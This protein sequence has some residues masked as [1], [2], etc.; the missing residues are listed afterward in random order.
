MPRIRGNGRGRAPVEPAGC[1]D[2]AFRAHYFYRD[3][4]ASDEYVGGFREWNDSSA[5]GIELAGRRIFDDSDDRTLFVGDPPCLEAPPGTEWARVGEE[6]EHGW[7]Q[8]FRPDE[9]SLPDVLASREGRFFLRVYDPDVSLLDSEAF[10]YV[11]DLRRIE[12]NGAEYGQD[13]MLV[14]TSTGH[15]RIEVRFVGIDGSTLTP[16]LPSQAQQAVAPSGAIIVPPHPDADR[17]QC[18]LESV[19]GAQ[20]DPLRLIDLDPGAA[21][22][23]RI[24][25][26][27][28]TAFTIP[29][30]PSTT[31]SS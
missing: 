27:A 21:A 17:I 9:Q 11:R 14:P 22:R 8:N 1:A 25:R 19:A 31:G 30:A 29:L 7:G 24:L 2:P 18:S 23:R 10:R 13:T 4:T 20:L 16:S 5:T 3:V 26:P 15:P 6:I 28:P 12:V